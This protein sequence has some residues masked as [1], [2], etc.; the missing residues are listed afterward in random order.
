MLYQFDQPSLRFPA[1]S[2]LAKPNNLILEAL[3]ADERSQ[4]LD[5]SKGIELKQGDVL[6]QPGMPI[7]HVY[8]PQAGLV[9]VLTVAN[10]GRA[11]ETGTIAHEGLVGGDVF[12]GL[13]QS[14]TRAR[15]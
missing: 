8:F 15:V 13:P 4:L 7:S 2:D 6:Q 12:L 1:A 5:R 3:A 11:I 10:D 14:R 9:S